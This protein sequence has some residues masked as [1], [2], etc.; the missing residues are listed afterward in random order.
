M[1]GKQ[2]G[3]TR[4]STLD[5]KAD[6]QLDGVSLDKT[7]EE[8]ASGKDIK[9][10]KLTECL[11]FLREDDT[12]HVHSIDRLARNLSDLL[13]IVRDL[14]GRGVAVRFHKERLTFTG[15]NNPMQD[16]QLAMLGAVAQFERALIRERQREG[17][18]VAKSNG[19]HLGRPRKLGPEQVEEIKTRAA[20][21]EKKVRLAEE[22]GISRPRIFAILKEQAE[23]DR[24]E[25]GT[26]RR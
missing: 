12:L 19:K 18:A 16:L 1:S 6:R 20:A 8:K 10:P 21:G 22:F 15:E 3:Y 26:G 13:S 23:T 14:T 7:F 4:V 9:R 24:R 5:Q 2:V 17:I 11:A 25:T